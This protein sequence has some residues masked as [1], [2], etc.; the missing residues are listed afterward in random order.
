MAFHHQDTKTTK[1]LSHLCIAA[2]DTEKNCV[3]TV[4][5]SWS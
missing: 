3:N 1:I 2:G 4:L 5:Y